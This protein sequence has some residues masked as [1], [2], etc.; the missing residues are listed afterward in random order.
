[1]AY[2]CPAAFWNV[3]KQPNR[4]IVPA[5]VVVSGQSEFP[6][7]LRVHRENLLFRSI[8]SVHQLHG[9]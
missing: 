8:L 3:E 6:V 1:M 2:G 9:S 7:H 5:D 4:L